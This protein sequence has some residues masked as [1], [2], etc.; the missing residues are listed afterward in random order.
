M[1]IGIDMG[2]TVSGPNYGAVGFMKESEETRRLG[3]VLID[4]LKSLG[5]TVINCSVDTA[6]SNSDSL[7]RR[8]KI[9]NSS[10][11]DIFI[12]IHFNAGGG[13]GSEILTFNSRKMPQATSILNNLSKLGLRNRGIKD[14]SHLFVVKNTSAPA[15]LVEVCFV[16]NTND[17]SLYTKNIN[18]IAKAI[19][20]GIV[21]ISFETPSNEPVNPPV[22]PTPPPPKPNPPV[23]PPI[24]FN[25]S[26]T[27]KLF[28]TGIN[29]N[30][31]T[32]LKVD[33]IFGPKTLAASPTIKVASKGD[34]VKAVQQ[35]LIIKGINLGPS[36]A[37]GIF[38]KATENGVKTIQRKFKLSIDGIVGPNTYKALFM[39]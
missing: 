20:D 37:D 31:K 29:S 32:K 6:S 22:K 28:Q 1:K 5:H 16:D 26:D 21:G 17:T 39:N 27:V 12:S 7:N 34:I 23:S 35:M 13:T 2:H 36:G 30:S 3:A 9:A 10:N 19:G 38:G 4:Y 8:V 15:L 25:K 24:K 14:G 33:G 18:N 11:L